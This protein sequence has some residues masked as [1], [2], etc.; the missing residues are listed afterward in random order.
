MS[1]LHE[2]DTPAV[3]IDRDRLQHNIDAMATFARNAGVGLRPHLKTH[4][5]REIAELQLAA[6]AR[7]LS[8]ATIGEAEVFAGFGM[9][10]LFIAYPL[11]L[12]D[13]KAA[14]LR[15]LATRAELSIGVD[16]L[17]AAR[18]LRGRGLDLVAVCI[19]LDSGH[20]RSGADPAELPAI[21]AEVTAAGCRIAGVFTFPG[22]SYIPGKTGQAAEQEA[23]TLNDAAELLSAAGHQVMVRSG[24]STPSATLTRPGAATEIRPGVYVFNDAQQLELQR[25]GWEDIA[26]HIA[27]TIVSHGPAED[28]LILDAGSK[29]I[30]SDRPAWAS[31]FARIMGEPDA[32]VTAL[33][34]HHATVVWPVER[35]PRPAIGER[36][37]VIPNHVCPVLNLVEEVTVVRGEHV[38]DTWR[39]VARGRNS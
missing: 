39:V 25:C 21:A 15:E 38:V 18:N 19:E 27:A 16:S 35:T 31:G 4:K 14:R 8:V 5:I 20:H 30:G 17:A 9:R 37:Q 22:H 36:V 24:G 3:V 2:I 29:I 11:W 10:D 13:T 12:R 1:L 26:L 32:R 6:G 23:R 7:G 34:E 33:S 28:T